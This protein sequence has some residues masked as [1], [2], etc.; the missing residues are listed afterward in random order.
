MPSSRQPRRLPV[1]HEHLWQAVYSGD[2]GM[3][4]SLHLMG[5]G[6]IVPSCRSCQWNGTT[7]CVLSLHSGAQ[8]A[9]SSVSRL[10]SPSRLSAYGSGLLLCFFFPPWGMLLLL[11]LLLC[12]RVCRSP[13]ESH[14]LLLVARSGFPSK[15]ADLSRYLKSDS[16]Q[17]STPMRVPLMLIP[18]RIP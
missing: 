15:N 12:L 11:R 7:V 5:Y 3:V 16:R 8:V 1:Q 17:E 9:P 13:M 6:A 2:S 14:V 18:R 10:P 4:A